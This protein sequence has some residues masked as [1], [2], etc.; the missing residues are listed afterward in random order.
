VPLRPDFYIGPQCPTRHVV[1]VSDPGT[2]A[3][4]RRSGQRQAF[5]H[6]ANDAGSGP[7]RSSPH[8]VGARRSCF[9]CPHC[10]VPW[11]SSPPWRGR[12]S[13]RCRFRCMTMAAVGVA[14]PAPLR[15]RVRHWCL[16]MPPLLGRHGAALRRRDPH[17]RS[18]SRW[19]RRSPR[20]CIDTLSLLASGR[21]G[22][23]CPVAGAAA[24]PSCRRARRERQGRNST[25][26]AAHLS[27]RGI[28]V[29]LR[30]PERH[31]R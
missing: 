31:R 3:N 22:R 10:V 2:G 26:V 19:A 12:G 15:L 24:R 30:A 25:A 5:L 29:Q 11:Q 20:S 1:V 21:G 18:H 23:R 17:L 27:Y 6:A 13:R 14:T 7:P 4:A 8:A 16:A 28:P 9:C